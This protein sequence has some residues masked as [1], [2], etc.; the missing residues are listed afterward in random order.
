MTCH[1]GSGT[2]TSTA[3]VFTN[4]SPAGVYA[5]FD[6]GTTWTPISSAGTPPSTAKH[7]KVSAAAAG[8]GN[9]WVTDGSKNVWEYNNASGTACSTGLGTCTWAQNTSGSIAGHANDVTINPLNGNQVAV[10]ATAGQLF[11]ATNGAAASPTFTSRSGSAAPGDSPWVV[12][13]AAAVTQFGV[14]GLDFDPLNNGTLL[15]HGSQWE[16][17][18]TFPATAFTW[19]ALS[20]GIQGAV[21]LGNI[22]VGSARSPT[23]GYEDVLGC[24]YSIATAASPPSGCA[25][26]SQ[27]ANGLFYYSGLSIAPGT[28]F[29]ASK[30]SDDFG[31]GFDLSG[32]STDGYKTNYL[33]YNRWN[34]SVD[35]G[36]GVASGAG[37][38]RLNVGSTAL[39]HSFAP[40]D[41]LSNNSIV[42]IVTTFFTST[43]SQNCWTINVIDASHIDLIGSTFA[44]NMATAGFTYTVYVPANPLDEWFG[45]GAV[46]NVVTA[47]GLVKV[48]Y[49]NAAGGNTAN[50]TPICISGVVMTGATIVN[51]CWVAINISGGTAQLQGSSFVGGDTYSTGGVVLSSAAPGGS[52]AVST[53]TNF[54]LY[55]ANRTF[56]L[57]T[58]DAG[59]NW[60]TPTIA[61]VPAVATT[62]TGGPYAAGTTSITVANGAA[63]DINKYVIL[64]HS[65]RYFDETGSTHSGNTVTLHTAIPPGDSLDTGANTYGDPATGGPFATFL[66]SHQM[67]ADQVT[68]NTFFYLNSIVGLV[69]WTNCGSTTIVATP[70]APSFLANSGN[71]DQLKAVPGQAGHLF[72]TAGAVGGGGASHPAA[73]LLWRTCNG[74]NSTASSVTMSS[75]AGFFEPRAVGFGIAA[76]GHSYPAIYVTGWYSPTND[77]NTATYGIWKSIDD[78][79]NGAT[80]SCAGG[81]TWTEISNVGGFPAGFPGNVQDIE[82][83]PFLYGPYYML[84]AFG[85]FYG[86]QNYLLNRDLNPAANDNSPAFLDKAA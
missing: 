51:G 83:D 15:G 79:N 70:G 23:F 27:G 16:W 64:L 45:Q 39:L 54:T 59:A 85:Q 28:T 48:T 61:G 76:P 12:N 55:G 73:N 82:G 8:G 66:R 43:L 25:L 78:A 31:T 9:V 6:A 3:Y 34:A 67:G 58:A 72:Y 50:R 33:P 22:Q 65:G 7:I 41:T 37:L 60:S 52:I 57:C 2:C 4:G 42:C 80:G 17:T 63:V 74:I 69:K 44:S 11:T 35:S 49:M 62:V 5:T 18:A 1:N 30:G 46:Q 77:R 71:N 13:T 38:V 68:P 47:A 56:P 19:A 26:P 36:T 29:M 81:N 84:G 40:G 21:S 20:S 32:Y 10:A 14:N 75:V 86:V 24:S 53:T